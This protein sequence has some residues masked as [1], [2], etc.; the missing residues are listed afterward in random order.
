MTQKK[1]NLRQHRWLELLKDYDLIIGYHP[2]LV[3]NAHT[4]EFNTSDNDN[5]YF[6]SRLCVPNDAEVKQDILHKAHS[7]VY[8]IHLGNNKMYNDL[9]QIY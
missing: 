9:K 5:L 7:S 3:E 1:L 4:T 2:G 8:S 6:H